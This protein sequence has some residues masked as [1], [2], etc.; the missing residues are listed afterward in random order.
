MKLDATARLGVL[1]GAA[2]FFLG[3]VSC[4]GQSSTVQRAIYQ[5]PVEREETGGVR[6]AVG[7]PESPDRREGRLFP[8]QFRHAGS[9]DTA[10]RAVRPATMVSETGPALRRNADTKAKAGAAS[11]R[12][13]ESKS[14]IDRGSGEQRG[15]GL[16]LAPPTSAA[17]SG[18]KAGGGAS[19]RGWLATTSSLAVLCGGLALIGWWLRK[20]SPAAAQ[21]LP[22]DV[23]ESLG[24]IPLAARHELH[25]VR[26]GGKLILLAV[27]PNGAAPVSEVVDPDEVERLMELCQRTTGGTVSS[28][29]RDVLTRF[30]PRAAWSAS[31]LN[32]TTTGNGAASVESRATESRGHQFREALDA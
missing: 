26:L 29:F 2:V 18:E 32:S 10:R 15:T 20:S 16:A 25:L 30:D 12:A 14:D 23:L 6:R 9:D 17:R 11:G 28:A 24:R 19:S 31:G 7:E 4:F 13:T 8:V 21:R 5:T 3:G 1:I 27:S 22:R